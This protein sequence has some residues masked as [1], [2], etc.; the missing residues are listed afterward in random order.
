MFKRRLVEDLIAQ[1]EEK[2]REFAD[3]LTR[4]VREHEA[5]LLARGREHEAKLL[6]YD[7]AVF[8][9]RDQKAEVEKTALGLQR[10]SQ[11]LAQA[12]QT[13]QEENE[14]IVSSLNTRLGQEQEIARV[15][16]AQVA[17]IMGSRG[18]QIIYLLW[19]IRIQLAPRGSRREALLKIPLRLVSLTIR[20]LTLIP[21]EGLWRVFKLSLARIARSIKGLWRRPMINL[22]RP[23]HRGQVLE[24]QSVVERRPEI[25]AHIKDVDIVVCVHNALEDVRG[26]LDSV[27]LHTT[28]PYRLIIVDDGSDSDT[29]R[30]LAA[31]VAQHADA[32][33][34]RNEAARGYTFAA[35]QGLRASS[36]SYALLLNSDTIVS[37][38]WLDRMLACA[39]TDPKIGIVGPLSN[40]ASWQSIPRIEDKGDW[41]ANPLP[42]GVSIPKMA[43]TS[44]CV[45][46]PAVPDDAS[47]QRFLPADQGFDAR[48]DGLVG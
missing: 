13:Q 20:A 48:R 2:E 38:G 17:E 44:G 12:M 19:Q 35:N 7:Q 29:A 3:L 26:C 23:E 47:P 5:I 36:S 10:E 21:Q 22:A 30:Y 40:T 1:A 46:G 18:F 27:L 8:A 11:R 31:F 9:L 25:L 42:P 28:K 6:E 15:A 37:P 41:A 4:R 39:E 32:A 33:L 43:E 14:Q 16:S 24:V 34:L 45:L